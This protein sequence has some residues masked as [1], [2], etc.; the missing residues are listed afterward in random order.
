MKRPSAAVI[1]LVVSAG[2]CVGF[3][4]YLIY[5]GLR[6]DAPSGFATP[7]EI[8]LGGGGL[9]AGVLGLAVFLGLVLRPAEPMR[10]QMPADDET[11]RV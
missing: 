11:P 3:T 7:A 8:Y 10:D 2:F 9:L 4:G 5:V 6:P 1:G